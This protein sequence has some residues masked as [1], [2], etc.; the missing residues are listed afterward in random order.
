MRRRGDLPGVEVERGGFLSFIVAGSVMASTLREELA[1]LRIERSEP[2]QDGRPRPARR[3]PGR[4]GGGLIRLLGWLLWMI[5]LGLLA[6]GGTFAYRQ[7]DM[8]RSRPEVT[9][10]VIERMTPGEAA[11]LLSATGYLKSRSQAM[12]GTKI[13]GRV[14]RMCVQ[15]G[16]KV[17]KGETLAVIEHREMDAILAS[18]EAQRLK[19]Q[20]ELAEARADLWEKEREEARVSRLNAQRK[21]TQEEYEKAV[22]G[23]QKAKARVAALEASVK[24][25][26]ANIDEMRSMIETMSL[27]APFDGTVVEKQGEEGEV[28][29]PTAMSSSLGRTAVVT[30]A[31]LTHMDVETD[32]SEGL[33]WRIAI[34]Q[35]AEVSVSAIPSKRY[36]GRLRQILPL[37]DRTRAT[38]K[39]KVEILDPDEHL[40]P[41]LAATVHFLPSQSIQSPD[42]NRVYLFVPRSA[43]FQENG[44]DHVWVIAAGD[45]LR[46]RRVEVATTND[47]RARVESGLSAGE[48]VV[49]NPTKALRNN[50]VVRV[51]Q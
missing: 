32:V 4:R 47:D 3:P 31:D 36:R 11:K 28:I 44:N 16:M 9:R 6:V 13:P 15:E 41:E 35:P 49:L 22:A 21:I 38:V 29:T 17:K 45:V 18:R 43:I 51:I 2:V 23:H 24:L 37:S 40:F 30:I 39:V 7:Y 20:A 1:S 12:I 46:K 14:E 19:N 42:V 33:L 10:A 34:G 26:Q 27:Y 5:P 50:E 8:I 25:S 48:A